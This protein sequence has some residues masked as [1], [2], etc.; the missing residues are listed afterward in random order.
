M[1]SNGLFQ[2]LLCTLQMELRHLCSE[3]TTSVMCASLHISIRA[4]RLNLLS[5]KM[6]V[7]FCHLLL[8]SFHIEKLLT[9]TLQK[10]AV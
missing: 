3:L 6:L 2:R 7:L 10:N 9:L 5:L 8:F 4:D 1:T